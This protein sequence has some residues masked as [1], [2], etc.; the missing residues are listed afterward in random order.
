MIRD[1]TSIS[2]W[3]LANKLSL[4]VTKTE[5]MIIGSIHKIANLGKP[6]D[7]TIGDK[8]IKRVTNTKYLGVHLDEQLTWT[9]HV[10]QLCAKANRAN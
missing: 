7:I 2:K 6:R 1:L 8:V 10:Q 3:L 5:Y 4:N 9:N